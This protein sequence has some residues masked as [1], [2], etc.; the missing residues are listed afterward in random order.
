MPSILG[1]NRRLHQAAPALGRTSTTVQKFCSNW[2]SA[3]SVASL[4]ISNSQAKWFELQ[5]NSSV[6]VSGL[7]LDATD[8]EMLKVFTKCGVIK[9]DD[10]RRPRIKIYKCASSSQFTLHS[11]EVVKVFFQVWRRQAG[12]RS[13]RPRIKIYKCACFGV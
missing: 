3:N 10:D 1:R 11:R 9:L 13:R 2:R 5:K 8:A 6:Y 12:R 4:Y 7:P